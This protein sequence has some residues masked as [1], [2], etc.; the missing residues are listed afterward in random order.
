M[1][2]LVEGF[3]DIRGD[4]PSI[5]YNGNGKH[6]QYN[7]VHRVHYFDS[8][9]MLVLHFLSNIWVTVYYLRFWLC[10]DLIGYTKSERSHNEMKEIYYQN[11]HLRLLLVGT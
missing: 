8:S 5:N 2:D 4:N 6:K 3:K 9:I 1:K 7:V 11:K 10:N